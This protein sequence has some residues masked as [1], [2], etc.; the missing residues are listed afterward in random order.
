MIGRKSHIYHS[1][2]HRKNTK[3]LCHRAKPSTLN[4]I[5][6]MKKPKPGITL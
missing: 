6:Q 1:I 5:E 3:P 4:V 2:K